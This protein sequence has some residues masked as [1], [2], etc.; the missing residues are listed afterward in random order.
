MKPTTALK[1][2]PSLPAKDRLIFPLDYATLREAEQAVSTLKDHVGIFK[3][4]LELFVTA[5]PAVLEG[6]SGGTDCRIFL[7]LKF[8]DIPH[9]ARAAARAALSGGLAFMTVHASGGKRLMEAAVEAAEGRAKILAVTVLTSLTREDLRR[10]G[11]ERDLDVM[12]LVLRRATLAKEAGCAG[13]VC[14]GAEVRAVKDRIGSE[15]LAVVPGIR[16]EWAPVAEDDQ[17][18]IVT[19]GEAIRNGADYLVVGR[20]I[21]SARDPAKAAARIVE[22]IRL[23]TV[24]SPLAK[25][26]I[27]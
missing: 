19:V 3:V 15:F 9:T 20:P 5:G 23:A 8:H 14:S 6:I 24:S 26:R 7:D 22:E 13:V 18:R 2:Q 17:R 4:G 11:F 25:K 12:G 10:D 21:R 27:D 1:K 16:P